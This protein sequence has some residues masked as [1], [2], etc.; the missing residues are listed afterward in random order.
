MTKA[1]GTIRDFYHNQV[2]GESILSLAI[3]GCDPQGIVDLKGKPLDVE[4]KRHRQK[5]SQDAN[6]LC[7]HICTEISKATGVSKE[8]V[9]RQNIRQGN[10]YTKMDILP[11]AIESF[12]RFWGEHGIGWFVDEVDYA[13]DNGMVTCFAY[14]GSSEYDTKQMSSLI[15][16]LLQDAE[17]VG[18]HI[19]VTSKEMQSI[20][21]DW[22]KKHEKRN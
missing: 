10:E 22:E 17:N 11:E 14:H 2:K 3:T 6:G 19:D 15:D 20:L 13:L 12:R 16:R 18:V 5:R 9:Y 4:I 8:E 7:W 1:K 21:A